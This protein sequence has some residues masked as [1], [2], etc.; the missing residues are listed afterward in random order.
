MA[1]SDRIAVM[2]HGVIQHIG[3]PKDIYQ[4]PA[5]TFV[6][7]FIGKTNLTTGRLLVR[8]GTCIL[9]FPSGYEVEVRSV[10]PEMQFEQDVVVSVR[11]EEYIVCDAAQP[12]IRATVS[13]NI[14]LGLN[15]HYTVSIDG[16][17]D[18]DIIQESSINSIIEKGTQVSLQIKADKINLFTADGASSLM[19]GVRDDRITEDKP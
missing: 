14:F 7:T 1:V 13:D 2:E 19:T 18:V 6:A 15:T 17:E 3:T 16:G 10:R 4:R 9:R 8:D 5:N 12:G 11:P